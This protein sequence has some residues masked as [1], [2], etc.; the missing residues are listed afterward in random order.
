[1]SGIGTYEVTVR[2]W[3]K[4]YDECK[5]LVRAEGDMDACQRVEQMVEHNP[6]MNGH[7]AGTVETQFDPTKDGYAYKAEKLP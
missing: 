5:V 4:T 3:Y 6:G 2:R 7:W 1:M